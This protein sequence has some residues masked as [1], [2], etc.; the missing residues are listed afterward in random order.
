MSAVQQRIGPR[1]KMEISSEALYH[2]TLNP[3]PR[4]LFLDADTSTSTPTKTP[5]LDEVNTKPTQNL[6]RYKICTVCDAK[7]KTG[8]YTLTRKNETTE[9]LRKVIGGGTDYDSHPHLKYICRECYRQLEKIE[10]DVKLKSSF[11]D[12]YWKTCSQ[13]KGQRNIGRMC[14]VCATT[15]TTG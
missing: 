2:M 5:P 15:L 1:C 4:L 10:K 8:G 9:R 13:C 7:N 14:L 11:V 6:N 3:P 12:S